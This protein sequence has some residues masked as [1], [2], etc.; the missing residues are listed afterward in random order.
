M[1]VAE[2][3]ER[4]VP[5]LNDQS[6]IILVDSIDV[7]IDVVDYWAAEHLEVMTRNAPAVA[8]RVRN[9]GAIFV[10]AYSPV[11]LGDYLAGS[12]HVLPTGGT[13][14]HSSGLSVQTFLEGI[15][16]VEYT[17][18]ALS[19]VADHIDAIGSAQRLFAHVAA[20]KVR[21]NGVRNDRGRR[22]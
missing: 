19:G 21:L 8:A 5:A 14:R 2:N 9:A 10:G 1:A 20:V 4:I 12:N 11:S 16:V 13:A 17:K 15:D 6:A 7:G 18:D 22:Q 3:R